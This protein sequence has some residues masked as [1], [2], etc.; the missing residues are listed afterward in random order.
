MSQWFLCH[1]TSLPRDGLSTQFAL[2]SQFLS[3]VEKEIAQ[4]QSQTFTRSSKRGGAEAAGQIAEFLAVS[5]LPIWGLLPRCQPPTENLRASLRCLSVSAFRS[6]QISNPQKCAKS[7]S[8]IHCQSLDISMPSSGSL[9]LTRMPE[10]AAR[11]FGRDAAAALAHSCAAP[12]P[13]T[14]WLP[15]TLLNEK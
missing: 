15:S 14:S 2:T 8:G 5:L 10:A 12:S 4:S 9:N 1:V 13:S 7:Y 11:I 6:I 3:S